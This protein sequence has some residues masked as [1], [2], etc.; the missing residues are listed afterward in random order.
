MMLWKCF[1]IVSC[2]V[3]KYSYIYFVIKCK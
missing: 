2:W 1:E 3:A